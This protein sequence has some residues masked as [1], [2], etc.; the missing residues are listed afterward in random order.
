MIKTNR[1]RIYNIILCSRVAWH[2]SQQCSLREGI[3]R[4]MSTDS[5]SSKC[6]R[7]CELENLDWNN[8]FVDF[9][10]NALIIIIISIC[11]GMNFRWGTC[12]LVSSCRCWLSIFVI[13]SRVNN[14]LTHSLTYNTC[15]LP[16]LEMVLHGLD[17]SGGLSSSSGVGRIILYSL[18]VVTWNHFRWLRNRDTL[19][20][21]DIPCQRHLKGIRLKI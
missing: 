7:L 2:S 17:G 19:F 8:M 20:S 11:Q 16:L 5:C 15:C 1:N 13:K 4:D 18:S 3:G 14:S 12:L 10:L 21:G 9:W 6:D